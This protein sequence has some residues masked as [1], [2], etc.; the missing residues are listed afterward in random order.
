MDKEACQAKKEDKGQE[1]MNIELRTCGK[2][3]AKKNG[4]HKK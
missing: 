4:C 3:E 2:K 1:K